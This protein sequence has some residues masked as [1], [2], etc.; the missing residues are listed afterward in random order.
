VLVQPGFLF[1]FEQESR[2]IVSL[3]TEPTVFCEGI[4]QIA[5][6]CREELGA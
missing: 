6:A 1:D 4:E 3:L 5:A 2:V